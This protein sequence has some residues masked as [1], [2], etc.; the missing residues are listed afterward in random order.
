[1]GCMSRGSFTCT[2]GD[3]FARGT[4]NRGPGIGKT[5]RNPDSRGGPRIPLHAEQV[6]TLFKMKTQTPFMNV[7]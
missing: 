1:M 2:W 3:W 5:V 4:H 6:Q 7:T